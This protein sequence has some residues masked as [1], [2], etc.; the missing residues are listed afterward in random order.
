M[1][2]LTLESASGTKRVRWYSI[3]ALILA[4]LLLASIVL[5]AVHD[6]NDRLSDVTAAIVNNDDGTEIDGQTVPLGRQLSAGLVEGSDNEAGIGNYDWVLTDDADAAE[7]LAEG[8]YAA[9]VTI[10]KDFSAKATSFSDAATA[11]RAIV[12]VETSDKQ[13][14]ADGAISN[15]ITST[16]A[17]VFGAT[18]SESFVDGILVGFNTLNDQLG[19][20]ADGAVELA[21]GTTQLADGLDQLADGTRASADGSQQLSTG[22]S[23]YMS[24]VTKLAD[25]LEQLRKGTKQLPAQVSG[26]ATGM[27]GIA[28]GV[29]GISQLAQA[30]PDMTLA[31]L[32]AYL[33]SQ[34]SSLAQ[35]AGGA[36]Q[37]ATG[38]SSLAKGLKQVAGGISA[39][40]SGAGQLASN[41]ST[42]SNGVGQ[43][44]DGLDQLAAGTSE[45][46]SGAQQLAEGTTELADGLGQAVEEIPT[47]TKSERDNLAGVVTSPVGTQSTS[48][49][50][51]VER[52]G[53]PL[54]LSL[55]LWIGAFAVY[56]V[57]QAVSR[58]ALSSRSSSVAL[59]AASLVPGVVV[60]AVQ[61]LA[62]A[63][64]MQV[65]LRL[66]VG[67]WFAL[68]GV[69]VLAGVAFAAV[70]QGIVA[71]LGNG[72][73]LLVALMAVVVLAAGLISTAPVVLTDLAALLPL[74]A[75]SR[76]VS[77]IITGSGSVGSAIGS[78]VLWGLIGFALSTAAVISRRTV[79]VR[80][81]SALPVD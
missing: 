18:L 61:G 8:R 33:A 58:R 81:L 80:Q 69:A 66:S 40:A 10:P 5:Y 70:V 12:D 21:D 16:A 34:G 56:F 19:T 52:S 24:G 60:G 74:D 76:A 71:V 77:A 46:A 79:R 22:V 67:D 31:E 62:L 53:L 29:G 48:I 26:I 9:V 45:T 25:G 38:T 32:D 7:G 72:G 49:G 30:Q 15:Y 42:L 4:P 68:A 50:N 51:L 47:Y 54:L 20:A 73:R 64:I 44:A 63:A 3:G 43:L 57:L 27:R 36:D 1:P 75:A 14:I 13:R 11:E 37:L 65:A 23:A 55:A 41:G 2:R 59:A 6:A 17:D 35:L 28:N 78:L 39:S